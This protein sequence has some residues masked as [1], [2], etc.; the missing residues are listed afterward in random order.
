[1]K[2]KS[3]TAH[4]Y[5]TKDRI[6]YLDEDTLYVYLGTDDKKK[7]DRNVNTYFCKGEGYNSL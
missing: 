5:I 1:M 6:V 4:T 7:I 2:I 3:V